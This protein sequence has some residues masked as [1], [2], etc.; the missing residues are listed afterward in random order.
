MRFG[1][2]ELQMDRL[3]Q[4]NINAGDAVNHILNFDRG[5]LVSAL[6]NEGFK[7]FELGGDLGLFFPSAYDQRN[8]QK[9]VEIKQLLDLS[10]TIHLPLWSVEP[11]TPLEPA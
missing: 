7:T 1:I 8:I 11:S 9:L 10:Y 6:A 4:P 5:L 3:I 2:M